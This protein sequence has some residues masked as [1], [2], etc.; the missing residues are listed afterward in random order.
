MDCSVVKTKLPDTYL[1]STTDY[2]FPLVDDPYMQGRIAACNVLSDMYAMGVVDID[3]MLMI[4]GVS[5]DMDDKE[6]DVVTTEMIR[7]FN[8]LAKEA[9]TTVTGGQTTM[10]QWPLI[11]GVATS[12]CKEGVDFLRPI[13]AIPGDV[14]VLT[15][16]LGMQLIVN[17]FE[18]THNGKYETVSDKITKEEIMEAYEKGCKS[19]SRLNRTGA[20]LMHKYHSHACTDVTGFG[21]IGHANNLASTQNEKVTFEIHTMPVVRNMLKVFIIYKF[22]NN[23]FYFVIDCSYITWL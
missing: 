12:I 17:G 8:D 16:P 10:N 9:G 22:S 15:K 3:T 13:Y 1:I 14:L 7:G 2:F 4:L 5:V 11:G 23:N 19:M 18:W 21:I 6:K 20:L